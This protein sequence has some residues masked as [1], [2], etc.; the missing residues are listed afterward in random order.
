MYKPS[1]LVE[2]SQIHP[3]I[4]AVRYLNNLRYLRERHGDF[5]DTRLS[6]KL[7]A[8]ASDTLLL[9]PREISRVAVDIT[10]EEP[11]I[12]L[13]DIPQLAEGRKN[14]RAK[15]KFGQLHF[16][17]Q[18]AG[19]M[20]ELVAAKFVH[21]LTAPRELHAALAIN[22]RFGAEVAFSP[23]GFIKSPSGKVGYLSR[24][25]HSV[26]TLDNILWN[27][28]ATAS[29]REDAMGFA[30]LWLAS[31]HNHGILHGDPQAKNIAYDSTKL[32]R[33]PDLEGASEI[34]Y[35]GLDPQ[36]QKLIDMQKLFNPTFMPPT[37]ADEE[38]AFVEAYT[39]QQ[40]KSRYRLDEM[41][42]MDSIAI[43]QKPLNR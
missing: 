28:T 34:G 16:A 22:Q 24:Y 39:D 37:S 27:D 33:Y 36:T 10:D 15:V 40:N 26:Q 19:T 2:G 12:S 35:G 14:S 23:I 9:L 13:I 43:A 4:R 25:E 11:E 18:S 17:N 30:G 38:M 32:P 20:A 41:D 8:T 1:T 21:R 31:I 29:Q 42:I 5:S 3:E 6:A 7:G